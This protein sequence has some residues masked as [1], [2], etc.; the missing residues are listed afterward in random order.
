M[1]DD[2]DT[3]DTVDD[4]KVAK[5]KIELE[6]DTDTRLTDVIS[7]VENHHSILKSQANAILAICAFLALLAI[8]H[9]RSSKTVTEVAQGFDDLVRQVMG[10]A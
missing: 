5:R 2:T 7:K 1:S 4:D 3:T 6:P 10:D 8:A 9:T